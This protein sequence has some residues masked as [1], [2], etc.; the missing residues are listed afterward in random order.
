M[1]QTLLVVNSK[2]PLPDLLVLY[3][4]NLLTDRLQ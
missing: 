1:I 3:Q 2:Q 4:F